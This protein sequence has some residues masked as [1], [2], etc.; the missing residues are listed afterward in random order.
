MIRFCALVVGCLALAGCSILTSHSVA[1]TEQKCNNPN[2]CDVAIRNPSCSIFGGCTAEVDFER[3]VFERGKN[4]FKV[5]W[6]LPPGYGFCDTAGDGVFL[7][8]TDR[9]GQFEVIGAGRPQ[10]EGRCNSSEFQ[11]RARNSKSL[12]NEPYTYKVVFHDAAGGKL[13]V[14]DPQMMNE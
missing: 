6:K 7:K 13:Y 12:P 14:I 3:V 1:V 10:G 4:N 9:Y 5:T 8:D 2:Q 11:L